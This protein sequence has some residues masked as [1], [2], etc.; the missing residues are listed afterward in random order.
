MDTVRP[1]VASERQWCPLPGWLDHGV[2]VMILPALPV[3]GLLCESNGKIGPAG[4]LGSCHFYC[5]DR[6]PCYWNQCPP[7]SLGFLFICFCFNSL[8]SFLG[9]YKSG[10][11]SYWE[12]CMLAVCTA[13]PHCLGADKLREPSP[14]HDSLAPL[15]VALPA[16]SQCQSLFSILYNYS[17]NKWTGETVCR[18]IKISSVL[19][20]HL[21]AYSM[22]TH[23]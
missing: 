10:G 15:A 1:T 17:F 22:T 12:S 23:T 5:F 20:K 16:A 14:Y 6:H 21:L 9:E 19:L 11:P 7:K 18:F 3:S 8:H 2:I 13:C 4:Y